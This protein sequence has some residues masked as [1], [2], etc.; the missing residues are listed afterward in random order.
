MSGMTTREVAKAMGRSKSWVATQIKERGLSRSKLTRT[1]V[2]AKRAKHCTALSQSFINYLDGLLISDGFLM[3]PS[4]NTQTS[5][6]S[7]DSVCKPWLI[8]VQKMLE[9]QGIKASV[10]PSKRR[11]QH[12]LRSHRYAELFDQY[13]RWYPDGEKR[14]P[15]DIDMS[16]R[17]LLRNWV[18]GDGTTGNDLRLCTDSFVLDDV[19][20]LISGLSEMGFGFRKVEMGLS[21][22]GQMKYRLSICKRTGL[23]DFIDYVGEPEVVEF[24]YKWRVGKC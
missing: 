23:L 19:D 5:G 16:D 15:R 17:G 18:Y 8:E 1:D 7:Q 4:K 3:R 6:Y 13:Q 2:L 11:G 21:K 9:F 22:S 24:S 10:K 14:V 12:V 20:F